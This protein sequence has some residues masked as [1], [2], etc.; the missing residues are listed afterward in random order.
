[1]G[2]SNA[3]GG[4]GGGTPLI[5]SW[6][7]GDGD[8]GAGAGDGDDRFF[9]A[10]E[11]GD[12]TI[13]RQWRTEEI[14]RLLG[15]RGNRA[16]VDHAI[17]LAWIA[18]AHRHVLADAHSLDE[19]EILMDESDAVIAAR[20]DR[21][22]H[23]S[24]G[25]VRQVYVDLAK[26]LGA[27]DAVHALLELVQREPPLANGRVEAL[28]HTFPIGVGHPHIPLLGSEVVRAWCEVASHARDPNQIRPRLG[29][30]GRRLLPAPAPE[31][32]LPAEDQFAEALRAGHHEVRAS[33]RARLGLD[34]ADPHAAGRHLDA[35]GARRRS[36]R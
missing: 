9:G 21:R 27:Q 7:Q 2:T 23:R 28:H 25:Q 3:Y 31:S 8:G 13:E 15:R 11:I 29:D 20:G 17:L 18:V 4:A 30:R 19:A 35:I 32:A 36:W 34:T 10:A 26:G 24:G 5:P 12:R 16:P 33:T 1:M 14:Q 22:A 6:L